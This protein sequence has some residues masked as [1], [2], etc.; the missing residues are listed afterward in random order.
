MQ[1]VLE[2]GSK[3]SELNAYEQKLFNELAARIR[4]GDVT[5]DGE[6]WRL[7]YTRT[8]PD[9]RTFVLDDYYLGRTLRPIPGENEGI[10]PTWLELLSRDFDLGSYIHNA[11]ITGSLGIGK[12]LGKGDLCLMYD[13]TKKP[14]QDIVAG[15]EL[16]GDDGTPRRVLSTTH[17]RGAMYRIHLEEGVSF[18]CNADHILCL[19]TRDSDAVEEVSVADFLKWPRSRQQAARMY[20]VGCDWPER[21][22]TLDPY[23]MGLWLGS[24]PSRRHP[25][26]VD[27]MM[28]E[29]LRN[30]KERLIPDDYLIN[31]RTVRSKLLAGLLGTAG[32][33]PCA[34]TYRLTAGS[35]QL[36]EQIQ[37]LAA[38]L[39]CTAHV[40]TVFVDKIAKHTVTVEYTPGVNS[41]LKTR[42][43]VTPIGQG[44]YY[45]FTISGNGRFLLGDF[46]VTHNTLC[47]VLLLLY[48]VC[49]ATCLKNPQ[50]FFGIS[51][52]SR[53]VYNF[54]SVTKEAVRDTAF[55]DAQNMMGGSPYFVEICGY[56]PDSD[57]SGFR[58]PLN[59]QLP[60]GRT[61]NIWITA[62]SKG[63]HLL[64]RN[65]V[66]VALDEGNFRL[67]KDPDLKAYALYDAVRTRISNRFQKL[68]TFLPALSLI[69]SSA[70]D[71]SSFTEKVVEE[72]EMQERRRQEHNAAHPD[73]LIPQTQIIYRNAVYRIKRHLLQDI[74][75]DHRWFRVAYGLKNME[76]YILEGWYTEDGTAVDGGVHE[77]PPSGARTE[78]VPKFYWEAFRRNCRTNLQALSGISTGGAHRLFASMID[79]EWCI[80]QSEIEGLQN[81]VAPGVDRIALSNED[82]LNI[83]DS[84]VHNRFVTRSASR[85][86][87]VR[88]PDRLRYAHIDLATQ[89]LCGIAVCHLVGA[90][91]VEGLVKDGVP[92]SEYRLV[93]EYDFIL[94]I[95][96]G[97]TKP[98]SIDKVQRFFFWL[99]DMCG[100]QFGLVTA[101][102]YQ[103][104][105]MLQM[106]EAKGFNVDRLSLDKDKQVYT[107]WRT[108][109]EE[110]RIRLMRNVQMMR[111]AEQLLEMDKKFDHP[112][113]G[114]KDTCD[115]AAGA[116]FNAINSEEKNSL[117]SQN[118]P[119]VATQKSD[120]DA[121][122]SA[123]H[124]IE[125]VLPASPYATRT[126]K[127]TA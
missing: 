12:C 60:D 49:I 67:E 51:R 7:D 65:V 21:P 62:G 71:E 6:L 88:H 11:V 23:W 99:R 76:P 31:S 36:A 77:E 53:I 121:P 46:T 104:V 116:Y 66:G 42:F 25:E 59:N 27:S 91:L 38:S 16:M 89:N 9:L 5:A 84:L 111:E 79:V 106:M 125:I 55:G 78:L 98:I 122:R 56:D 102:M 29:V 110:R 4:A 3:D 105:S 58:I 64:G 93:I 35:R 33:R 81:P 68:S 108:G 74:G 13:G 63:Q 72:I 61:S 119:T 96:A 82:N 20:R 2:G 8:P 95:C 114:S 73:Q 54:L 75:P 124:P 28:P 30:A 19:K 112:D 117:A 113:S 14:V 90:Q 18:S 37:F 44:T 24:R 127:F 10:W 100:F 80:N 47:S 83:W 109:F 85:H 39:G 103:S 22:V 118:A 107:T 69:A 57:Y 115:A 97:N 1:D 45:G 120:T 70:A 94:T 34:D 101:D 17:G 32:S 40:S 43:S 41:N 26:L 86:L 48:R 126:K 52:G 87:P 92:F 50:H 123:T 15:E